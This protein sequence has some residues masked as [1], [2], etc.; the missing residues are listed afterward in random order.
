MTLPQPAGSFNPCKDTG[1]GTDVVQTIKPFG[2]GFSLPNRDHGHS[3]A[4]WLHV[5]KRGKELRLAWNPSEVGIIA[6]YYNAVGGCPLGL[7]KCVIARP[8]PTELL[9]LQA[10]TPG[11]EMESAP[12][13]KKEEMDMKDDS[14]KDLTEMM[15][16]MSTMANPR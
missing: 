11:R 8:N 2:E 5:V 4:Q 16:S 7:R 12:D 15:Q 6:G 3:V 1:T 13:G 14:M 10:R 9:G